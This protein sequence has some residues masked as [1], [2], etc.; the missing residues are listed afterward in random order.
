MK[1]DPEIFIF[2]EDTK[3][4]KAGLSQQSHTSLLCLPLPP[5]FIMPCLL[6]GILPTHP[7]FGHVS[8]ALESLFQLSAGHLCKL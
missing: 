1:D 8:F 2:N 6:V 3:R 4:F 7:M 5:P